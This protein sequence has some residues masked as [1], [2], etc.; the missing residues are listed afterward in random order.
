MVMIVDHWRIN[1]PGLAVEEN[2]DFKFLPY[3]DW[4]VKIK[5][6]LDQNWLEIKFD[7]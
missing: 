7:Q 1:A 4:V 6:Q 5:G 2:F 3:Q